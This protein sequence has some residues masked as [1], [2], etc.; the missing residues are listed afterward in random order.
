MDVVQKGLK[1]NLWNFLQLF[2]MVFSNYSRSLKFVA[3]KIFHLWTQKCQKFNLKKGAFDTLLLLFVKSILGASR[4]LNELKSDW[5][6]HLVG[7]YPFFN[8]F[9][10]FFNIASKIKGTNGHNLQKVLAFDETGDLHSIWLDFNV[11]VNCRS[12]LSKL[13]AVM[14]AN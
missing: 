11:C 7:F 3:L 1:P 14:R 2:I 4:A 13:E 10:L 9:Y 6:C 12:S 8:Y 5:K